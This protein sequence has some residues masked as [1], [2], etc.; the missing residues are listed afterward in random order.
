MAL[1]GWLFKFYRKYIYIRGAQIVVASASKFCMV[2]S[3]IFSIIIAVFF[4]PPSQ[5]SV[6]VH[7]LQAES[8]G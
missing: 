5:K 4:P 6:T 2:A 3:N 7:M 1:V 8:A